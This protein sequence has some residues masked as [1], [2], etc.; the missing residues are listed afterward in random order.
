MTKLYLTVAVCAIIIGAYFY[1][2]N[3]SNIKCRASYLQNE[4]N[5]NIQNYNNQRI[6][7]D[8]VYKTGV[9]DIRRILFDKYS[10]AE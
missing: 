3:I 5:Q 4:L 6:I 1:G 10:I 9:D 8:T 7:H 2:R